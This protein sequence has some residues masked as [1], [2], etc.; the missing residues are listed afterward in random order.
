[1]FCNPSQFFSSRLEK[2]NISFISLT[3]ENF[4]TTASNSI[5]SYA[6]DIST[7]RKLET[8]RRYATELRENCLK[9]V[10]QLEVDMG[11]ERR[12]DPSSSEY[13]ETLGYMS[14]RTYQR[15]LEELQRLVIQRLFELHKMNISAT[16]NCVYYFIPRDLPT[17]TAY[18]M[19]THIAK[20]L[21]S[22]CKAIRNA[23]KTYN[24]A[25]AQLDPPR[26]SI[27]WEHVSHINFLEEFNL[28][29][30]TRQDIR[31]KRWS[32]PAIRELMKSFQRVKRAREEIER[33]NV[34]VRRLYTAILD[35]NDKFGE[36]LSQPQLTA[37]PVIGAVKDFTDR[38]RR[39]NSLLLAKLEHLGRSQGFSGD[40]SRGTRLG[41]DIF[42]RRGSD[43]QAAVDRNTKEMGDEE[44]DE[45]FEEMDELV[46]H[47][48]DYVGDLAISS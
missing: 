16:G 19:R 9:Q 18:H 44:E 42:H 21:Q 8:E 45:D 5:K 14:T 27:S 36:A 23:V 15:A 46:S 6:H 1:M 48:V 47:L 26:P 2:A 43:L 13:L 30:N 22:R 35:E 12:W 37:S 4:Y 17:H 38:R 32:Q 3:P 29:H 28:L 24:A 11:I 25:A 41:S 7:T 20:A 40:F 39:V 33:C 31:E 34:A 10:I